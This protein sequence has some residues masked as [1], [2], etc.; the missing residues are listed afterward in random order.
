MQRGWAFER[1]TLWVH[2]TA[3][4]PP[5]PVAARVAVDFGEVQ[6]DA[7]AA[8]AA[9]MGT[10]D[11]EAIRRR[12]SGERRC[13]VAW[14][15][16]AIGAYGWASRGSEWVGELE[17]AFRLQG[18]EAYIWDCVTLPGYRGRRLYSA[19]LAFMLGQLR[20][21]GVRRTWIGASLDNRPSIKGFANAGFQPVIKLTYMRLLGL[22]CGWL[23][24]HRGA[25]GQLVAAARRVLVAADERTVG[26]LVVGFGVPTLAAEMGL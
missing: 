12:F 15:D 18:D 9:A 20:R 4:A 2:D 10:P 14:V 16:G 13:F 11:V 17:R 5:A 25:D 26:P 7:S 23:T 1:G 21:A 6:R 19:L 24:G 8:L 22:R 3:G